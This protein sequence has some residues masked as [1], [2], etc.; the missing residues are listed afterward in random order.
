[1]NMAPHAFGRPG[2]LVGC[3]LCVLTAPATVAGSGQSG[4]APPGLA[5]AVRDVLPDA[6]TW[7]FEE[8][9]VGLFDL[10]RAV[11]VSLPPHE[12]EGRATKYWTVRCEHRVD[13]KVWDC[14]RTPPYVRL[15]IQPPTDAEV[16]ASPVR[17]LRNVS[18][19]PMEQLLEVVDTVRHAPSLEADL[20]AVCENT[21]RPRTEPFDEWRCEIS[22]VSMADGL[23]YVSRPAGLGCSSGF[24]FRRSC[25]GT[26][27]CVLTPVGCTMA[28][29]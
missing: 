12:R 18:E 2:V 7:T 20:S 10:D 4:S 17:A 15:E 5:E 16:C 23:V 22:A 28:C 26:D 14:T 21:W 1:M 27:D 3:T 8:T 13:T 19:L 11:L 6:S 9:G 25:S 29:T 24:V